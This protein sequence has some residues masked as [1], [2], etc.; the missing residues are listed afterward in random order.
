MDEVAIYRTAISATRIAS[1][2]RYLGPVPQVDRSRLTANAV[3]VDIFE[4]LPD[5]R[6][7]AFSGSQRTDSYLAGAFG[8]VD[9]PK[10]YSPQA[11]QIDRS[12]PFLVRA[13][14]EFTLAEGPWQILIRCRNAGR[15][16]VDGRLIAETPFHSIS[17]SGHGKVVRPT[18]SLRRTFDRWHEATARRWPASKATASHT[19]SSSN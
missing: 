18:T 13:A 12:S 11:V 17:A 3:L 15:L 4:P 5:R 2:F 6:H 19:C 9:V 10:K 1:R 7:V 8:F 16:Y 14:G